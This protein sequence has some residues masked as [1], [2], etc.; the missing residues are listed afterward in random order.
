MSPGRTWL[1]LVA[2]ARNHRYQQGLF[3]AAA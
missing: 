3:Q 2:G 1:K